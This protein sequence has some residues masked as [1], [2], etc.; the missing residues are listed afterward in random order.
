LVNGGE[1]GIDAGGLKLEAGINEY[2]KPSSSFELRKTS[3]VTSINND[4]RVSSLIKRRRDEV[5]LHHL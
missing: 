4:I 5:L 3:F 1:A 2:I